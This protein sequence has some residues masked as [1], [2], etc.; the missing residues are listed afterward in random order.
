MKRTVWQRRMRRQYQ[1]QQRKIASIRSGSPIRIN[2][3]H[4]Y[5]Q[6]VGLRTKANDKMT[7]TCKQ[8][9][10]SMSQYLALQQRARWTAEQQRTYESMSQS[11]KRWRARAWRSG[12]VMQVVYNIRAIGM[13]VYRIVQW[14]IT[15]FTYSLDC[16]QATRANHEHEQKS[17]GKMINNSLP[18]VN[19]DLSWCRKPTEPITPTSF[20]QLTWAS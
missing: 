9:E 14:V 13:A 6:R 17:S 16:V 18:T 7:K 10:W 4:N 11:G 8:A 12:E 1:S 3:F 15:R 20:A 5:L 19:N 2:N